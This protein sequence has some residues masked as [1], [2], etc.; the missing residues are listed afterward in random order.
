MTIVLSNKLNWQ[1]DVKT[2]NNII[3]QI[4]SSEKEPL[5][6][7]IHLGIQSSFGG[8]YHTLQLDSDVFDSDFYIGNMGMLY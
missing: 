4:H 1:N 8:T 5:Y 7:S 6:S 2:M 3:K